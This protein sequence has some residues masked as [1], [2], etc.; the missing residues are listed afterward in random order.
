MSEIKT[1]I[2]QP[3]TRRQILDSSNLKEFADGNSKFDENGSKL[4]R[5]IENIVGKGELDR[6][7]QFLL[8]PLCFQKGC[9]LGASKSVIVLEWIKRTKIQIRRLNYKYYIARAS[10][11]LKMYQ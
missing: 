4:S 11:W 8:F 10:L 1:S 2:N 9:F 5:R 3:I 6:Y 7:E